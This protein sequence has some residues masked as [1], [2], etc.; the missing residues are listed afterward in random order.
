[1]WERKSLYLTGC[2]VERVLVRRVSVVG[3]GVTDGSANGI[4]CVLRN[5]PGSGIGGSVAFLDVLSFSFEAGAQGGGL[6]GT[7]LSRYT[8][9]GTGVCKTRGC[10]ES[11]LEELCVA[12]AAKVCCSGTWRVLCFPDFRTSAATGMPFDVVGLVAE[13]ST[14]CDVRAWDACCRAGVGMRVGFFPGRN[15]W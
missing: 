5:G 3:F 12:G 7:L 15:S 6:L 8:G 14:R 4:F 11:P 1:M 2:L 10:V 9:S 13:R